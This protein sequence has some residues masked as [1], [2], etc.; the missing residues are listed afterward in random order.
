LY[1]K[2]SVAISDPWNYTLFE[3]DSIT[4][5]IY[6]SDSIVYFYNKFSTNYNNGIDTMLNQILVYKKSVCR[7]MLEGVTE[8]EYL[9]PA[10]SFGDTTVYNNN[11][12]Y[13]RKNNY[14]GLDTIGNES[15]QRIVI[16]WSGHIQDITD[17]KSSISV[18][19]SDFEVYFNT[20]YGFSKELYFGWGL[21]IYEVIGGIIDGKKY[22]ITDLPTSLPNGNSVNSLIIYPNPAQ[23]FISINPAGRIYRYKICNLFG[24][25]MLDGISEGK[26]IDISRLGK[27]LYFMKI[28]I[29]S[30]T[31][32]KKFIK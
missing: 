24:E 27:G 19:D 15:Y 25:T 29:E 7:E 21:S 4:S 11:Y 8:W 23:D 5:T 26:N 20:L 28:N 3:K 30:I 16:Y 6:T 13:W 32:F 2:E 1:K 12:L 10:L 22:G 18:S 17:C 31:Y 9:T 14:Y